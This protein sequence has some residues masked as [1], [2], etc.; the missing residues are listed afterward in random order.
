M[1]AKLVP[2]L[3]L[4]SQLPST[5]A[6]LA[7]SASY[8]GI[9][10]TSD[11]FPDCPGPPQPCFDG[12]AAFFSNE[13]GVMTFSFPSAS[14]SFE[15][16]GYIRNQ[17]GLATVCFDGATSGAGC[18]TVSYFNANANQQTELPSQ[19][20]GI[21][22]LTNTIHV[23]KITN[24]PDTNNGGVLGQINVDHVV[25]DGTPVTVPTFPSNSQLT[26]IPISGDIVGNSPYQLPL[27]LG[28]GAT[29]LDCEY[30]ADRF[31]AYPF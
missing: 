25:I 14:T 17:A 26:T 2:F 28:A 4:L 23:V 29:P 18:H 5:L 7:L 11:W 3:A 15:W 6:S 16:W 9:V 8:P 12:C 27:L 24:I 13:A 22:G 19:F 10:Y 1:A 30:A 20:F 21:T 31:R